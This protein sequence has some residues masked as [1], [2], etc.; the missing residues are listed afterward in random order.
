[1]KYRLAASLLAV[2]GAAL[3]WWAT[4][5]WVVAAV[6]LLLWANNMSTAKWVGEALAEE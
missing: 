1:M 6:A 5:G 2:S 4:S 3:L